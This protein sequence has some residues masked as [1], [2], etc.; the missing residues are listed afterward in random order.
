[1]LLGLHVDGLEVFGKIN[2]VY[3]KA[4]ELFRVELTDSDRKDQSIRMTWN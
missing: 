3:S 4:R 1:M 2:L